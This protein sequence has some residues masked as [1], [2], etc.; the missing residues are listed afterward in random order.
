M[1]D[2]VSTKP[3]I[4]I[5]AVEI[6]RGPHGRWIP[7]PAGTPQNIADVGAQTF[8]LSGI[9][10]PILEAHRAFK[11]KRYAAKIAD[12]NYHGPRIVAEGDSWFEYPYNDDL[13]MILGEKYAI[14][15][16]AKAGDDWVD[17]HQENELLPA[18][19]QQK[20]QI[21]MLSV[22]GNEVMGQ[23]ETF[24]GQF[25]LNQ[26]A[27]DYILPNF[28]KML[29]W[30]SNQYVTTIPDILAQ[31]AQVIV[32]GYDYPDPREPQTQGAQWIGPPLKESCSIDGVAMWRQIANIMIDRY[33]EMMGK[34][35][36]TPAFAGRVHYV[37]LR[38]TIGNSDY[39]TGPDRDLWNDEIHGTAAGFGKLA[40]KIDPVIQKIS[41]PVAAAV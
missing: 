7:V 3:D 31:G 41:A 19:K 21:V 9:L 32:H 29:D 1:P 33:N 39:D 14:M 16:L 35:A 27:A 34:M 17:V 11:N 4:P 40:A 10:D 24:V 26:A 6:R 36:A 20:P 25:K 28:S 22:G 5:H 38:G 23:I 37:D 8:A 18:I 30:I 12:P 15:S 13:I 2:D